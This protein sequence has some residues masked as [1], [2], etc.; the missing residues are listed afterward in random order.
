MIE[1]KFIIFEFFILYF[2]KQNII[3][4]RKIE[5]QF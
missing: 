1:K 3:Y 2:Q 4:L 5:K